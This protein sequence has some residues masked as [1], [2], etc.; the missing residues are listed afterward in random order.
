[1]NK[2]FDPGEARNHVALA[3][4]WGLFLREGLPNRIICNGTQG[5]KITNIKFD[6]E[7][8]VLN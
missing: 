4:I 3:E 6:G 7:V 1:L 5:F 8:V 2:D